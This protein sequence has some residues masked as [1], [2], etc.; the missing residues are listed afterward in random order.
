MKKSFNRV[1]LR[2]ITETEVVLN[3][4]TLYI[5]SFEAEFS[6]SPQN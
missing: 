4:S 3:L 1:Y 2:K 5:A 6:K